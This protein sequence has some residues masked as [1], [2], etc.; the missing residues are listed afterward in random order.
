M[1]LGVLGVAAC[2][3]C[4]NVPSTQ[5]DPGAVF[6]TITVDGDSRSSAQC[7]ATWSV[8]NGIGATTIV[9]SGNDRVTCNDGTREVLLGEQDL[10][11]H[12]SYTASVAYAPGTTYVVTLVYAGKSYASSVQLPAGV[13]ISGPSSGQ[14]VK[15]GSQ[16]SLTW[17][18]AGATAM[19]FEMV[20]TLTD[21]VSQFDS[22]A[23]QGVHTTGPAFTKT[24]AASGQPLTGAAPATVKFIR[25]EDGSFVAAGLM[26]GTISATQTDSVGI[27]LVD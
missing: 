19:R 6:G 1:R 4:A 14:T 7:T 11:G 24:L 26:G 5:V 27:N 3:G 22:S 15:K 10:L 9:L 2:I 16:L 8:G 13:S 23:D 17:A 20:P 12:V 21:A 25:V 18:G